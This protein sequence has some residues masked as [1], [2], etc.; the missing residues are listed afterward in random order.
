MIYPEHPF[1]TVNDDLTAEQLLGK[2]NEL[3]AKL[4]SVYRMMNPN[5]YVINQI[6]MALNTYQIKYNEKLRKNTDD[7]NLD[8]LIDVR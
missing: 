7:S 1:I 6:Q 5:V 2:I 4:S 8:D 3:N